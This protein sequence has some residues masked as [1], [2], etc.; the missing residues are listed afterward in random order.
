MLLV[1]GEDDRY[2]EGKIICVNS[3]RARGETIQSAR[4][5]AI[6]DAIADF[7][8]AT[9]PKGVTGGS[10]VGRKFATAAFTRER[11][12]IWRACT[13]Q[14]GE[15]YSSFCAACTNRTVYAHVHGKC[16]TIYVPY[17]DRSYA[18]CFHKYSD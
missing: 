11:L 12:I 2:P 3:L 13:V 14:L 4:R 10:F 7:L 9:P 5:N 1:L 8:V 17:N 16:D 18:G 15:G 6:R